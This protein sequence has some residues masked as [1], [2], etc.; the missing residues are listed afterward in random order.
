MSVAEKNIKKFILWLLKVG[1]SILILL[2]I[3]IFIYS[4]FW[5]PDEK[6]ARSLV[7]SIFH[8]YPPTSTKLIF[9]KNYWA[10]FD[11]HEPRS[12]CLIFQYSQKDFV[13][14]QNVDFL[15]KNNKDIF[16]SFSPIADN[17]GCAKFNPNLKTQNSASFMKH[18]EYFHR[19]EGGTIFVDRNN[20]IVMFEIYLFD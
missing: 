12:M 10:S 20:R 15:T 18:F 1:S 7:R 8:Y 17:K 2:V 4:S 5:T 16:Y 14:F 13:G 3:L 6:K 11:G 9:S 19:L